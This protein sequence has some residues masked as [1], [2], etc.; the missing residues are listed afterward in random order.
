MAALSLSSLP[1]GGSG[2]QAA[3]ECGGTSGDRGDCGVEQAAALSRYTVESGVPHPGC[4]DPPPS[5]SSREKPP[6]TVTPAMAQTST[7]S[8]CT[9]TGMIAA[10][11]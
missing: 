9:G 1:R 6:R 10:T 2:A 5:I 11:L 7:G 3:A 4:W 8:T